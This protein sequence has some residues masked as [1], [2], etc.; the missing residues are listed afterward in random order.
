MG[1]NVQVVE[2][3]AAKGQGLQELEDALSLQVCVIM[4]GWVG[5]CTGVVVMVLYNACMMLC[6]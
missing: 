2:V 4:W 6:V 1:G 5:G 3:A